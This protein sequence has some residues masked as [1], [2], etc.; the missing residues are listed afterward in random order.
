VL[1]QILAAEQIAA[2]DK[3]AAG[4]TLDAVARGKDSPV[5]LRQLALLKSVILRGPGMTPEAREAA[6]AEL[7]APGAPFRVLAIEQ[8]ALEMVAAGRRDEAVT[9]LRQLLQDAEATQALRA[10]VAQLMVALGADPEAA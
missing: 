9:L 1:G 10:R 6:L 4:A 7:V 8:Q 2:G 5:R 3:A